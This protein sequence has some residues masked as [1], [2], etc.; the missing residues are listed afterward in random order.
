MADGPVLA[1]PPVTPTFLS[2]DVT[3]PLDT[4]DFAQ[5]M[6]QTLHWG[7]HLNGAPSPL[8]FIEQVGS[9]KTPIFMPCGQKGTDLNDD[10]F[11]K[12]AHNIQEQL[13]DPS[14]SMGKHPGIFYVSGH[15]IPGFIFSESHV[16]IGTSISIGEAGNPGTVA[17]P[18]KQWDNPHL[19]YI[20]FATCRQLDGAPQQA[21]WARAMRGKQPLHGI[22]GYRDT[23]P[24]AQNCAAINRDFITGLNGAKGKKSKTFL[25]AWREAHSGGL[26]ARWAALIH[27]SAL[28]DKI[29]EWSISGNLDSVKD[30]AGDILYFDET[31]FA[32]GGIVVSEP[33]RELDVFL[34]KVNFRTKVHQWVDARNDQKALISIRFTDASSSAFQEG[35]RIWVAI[36]Q[37]RPNFVSPVPYDIRRIFSII[38][39]RDGSTVSPT[40][41]EIEKNGIRAISKVRSRKILNTDGDL[42]TY[43]FKIPETVEELR[44]ILKNWF[45]ISPDFKQ[46]QLPIK[47]GDFFNGRHPV[48]YFM[49]RVKKIDGKTFGIPTKGRSESVDEKKLKD[50]FQFAVFLLNFNLF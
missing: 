27:R 47:F 40:G 25:H 15:G 43:E 29:E 42:D 41:K 3:S 17:S 19:K 9:S 34:T 38:S 26:S 24:A 36:L 8:K 32:K 21:L 48:F 50:D 28:D 7:N 14:H 39:A 22:L 12:D 49:V 46:I 23:S 18:R 1:R 44:K 5:R 2:W 4:V 6:Q 31:N 13:F 10:L 11:L 37:V 20:I 33:K 16:L 45:F 30:P 35:D